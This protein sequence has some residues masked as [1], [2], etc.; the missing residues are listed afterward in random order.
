MIVETIDGDAKPER[1]GKAVLGAASKVQGGIMN[2]AYIQPATPAWE[3]CG[4]PCPAGQYMSIRAQRF[5][6]PERKRGTEQVAEHIHAMSTFED[7]RSK[8]VTKI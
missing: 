1:R 8:R 5:A 6:F 3:G 7:V 2:V 4:N